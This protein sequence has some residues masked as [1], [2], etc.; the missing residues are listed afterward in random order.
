MEC[1]S[2]HSSQSHNHNKI[3]VYNGERSLSDITHMKRISSYRALER[4]GRVQL[5]KSFFMRDML[6]SEISNYYGIP[7]IPVYPDTAIEA[8]KRLC[9]T[10]LEPLQDQFGR[11]TIRS[12]YRSPSVND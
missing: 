6:Y 9:G 3:L 4:L 7:N 5:S 8:G 12:A 11:I 1:T 2:V 10:L